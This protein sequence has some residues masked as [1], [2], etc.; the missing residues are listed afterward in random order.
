MNQYLSLELK[1][2]NM[3][4]LMEGL[5]RAGFHDIEAQGSFLHALHSSGEPVVI[6]NG[7]IMAQGAISP[8]L[9]PVAYATAVVRATYE[10]FNDGNTAAPTGW[11]LEVVDDGRLRIRF[12][13]LTPRMILAEF[14][15]VLAGVAGPLSFT[16]WPTSPMLAYLKGRVE[17]KSVRS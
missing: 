4:L 9:V 17:N 14:V 16:P 2:N 10:R 7:V 13:D 6:N 5:E 8:R 3:V 12:D 1:I 11:S 15:E